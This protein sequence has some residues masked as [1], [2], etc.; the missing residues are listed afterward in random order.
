MSDRLTQELDREGNSIHETNVAFGFGFAVARYSVA[1]KEDGARS[2]SI[3][4][5]VMKSGIDL[6]PHLSAKSRERVLEECR[7]S[8]AVWR[9]AA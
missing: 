1:E 8:Y 2:I 9:L 6:L 4:A 5:L 3:H 7:K